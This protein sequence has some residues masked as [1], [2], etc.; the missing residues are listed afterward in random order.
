MQK[1]LRWMC[2]AALL[3]LTLV[4]ACGGGGGRGEDPSA[5]TLASQELNSINSAI[6]ANNYSWTAAENS[7]SRLASEDRIVL[8]G[9][10][11]TGAS[12]PAAGPARGAS[13][14]A[15][16]LATALDWRNASG[17]Y[18]VPAVKTQGVC[19]SSAA[20]ALL[21][22]FESVS[23][24]ANNNALL[25]VDYSEADLFS[26]GGGSCT[27][28]WTMSSAA[29]RLQTAG[30]VDEACLQY[31]ASDSVCANKCSDWQ[32]RTTKLDSWE[33][34][35]SGDT[36]AIKTA[37]A[38][39]P[40]AAIINV[41]T[42]F[43]YYKSGVFKHAYGDLQGRH[44][45][46]IIGYNDAGGYWIIQNSWGTDWGESGFARVAYGQ[47]G[48]EDYVM[49]LTVS[50]NPATVSALASETSLALAGGSAQVDVSCISSG[51]VS[52]LEV[53]CDSALGWESMTTGTTTKTC[54]YTTAGSYTPG[55]RVNSA[56]SDNVD[57][58]ITVGEITVTAAVTPSSGDAGTTGFTVTCSTSGAT[59][60]AVEYRCDSVDAWTSGRTGV[61]TYSIA[62]SYIPGCRVNQ[63]SIDNVDTPVTVTGGSDVSVTASVSPASG[64]TNDSYTVTCTTTGT[65][66]SASYR[67]DTVG[68]W[69]NGK[70]GV[71]SYGYPGSYTPG[72]RVNSAIIDNVDSAVTVTQYTPPV[73]NVTVTAGVSPTA[74]D[75]STTFILT[76]TPSSTPTSLKYRCDTLDSWVSITSG[77]TAT[78]QY[79]FAGSY[80]PA[81]YVN[82]SAADTVDV[83]VGVQASSVEIS[84]SPNPAGI[85]AN[86][87]I[88]CDVT[89]ALPTQLEFRCDS[90]GAWTAITTGRTGTCVYNAAGTYYPGCRVNGAVVDN[91]G[92][93]ASETA[94]SVP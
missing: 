71:C 75:T 72:C 43:Y 33:W 13:R 63:A 64:T 93:E 24:V 44:A 66:T 40:V 47:I 81:C 22:V 67:C 79:S 9:I 12:R 86:V 94:V 30:V 1:A 87:T 8:N 20:F 21:T 42:D 31:S 29:T 54:T 60:S 36:T 34:L 77:N 16:Q 7:I 41:Y 80:Y 85:G 49:A 89:G 11:G 26:C 10:S 70:T 2:L 53:R 83:A 84:A 27:T 58:A 15:A 68:T 69:Q 65:P 17:N 5:A 62:G 6:A 32:T 91:L 76:C 74:G 78:C 37:L 23:R 52:K 73:N 4:P 46:A 14:Q 57:T 45:V 35:A 18:W 92:D 61:C 38:D 3:G 39:G 59:P 28:G 25:N 48:I 50:G 88:T 55:C 51:A 90:V 56:T 19:G 82:D